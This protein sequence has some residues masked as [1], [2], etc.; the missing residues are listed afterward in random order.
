LVDKF[1]LIVTPTTIALGGLLFLGLRILSFW[2][3]I[4]GLLGLG[5]CLG[6][7]IT[8]F[9]IDFWLR[10]YEVLEHH[11]GWHY[12]LTQDG[13]SDVE[14]ALEENADGRRDKIEGNELRD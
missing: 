11:E 13:G 3:S 8:Y 7:I 14:K 10:D 6:S 1:W 2:L 9:V 12:E 5:V 4:A